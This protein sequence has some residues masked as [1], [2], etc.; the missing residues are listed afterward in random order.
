LLNKGNTN[1][2]NCEVVKVP[3]R[4]WVA[5]HIEDPLNCYETNQKKKDSCS[6]RHGSQGFRWKGLKVS[7]SIGVKS[8]S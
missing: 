5:V 7:Q 8:K 4:G 6:S 1:S 3:S 2:Y